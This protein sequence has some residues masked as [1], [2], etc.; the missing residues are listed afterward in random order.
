MEDLEAA[1]AG[2]EGG[3]FGGVVCGA[4][5][6]LLE[7]LCARGVSKRCKRSGGTISFTLDEAAAHAEALS[8]GRLLS[9]RIWRLSKRA[10]TGSLTMDEALQ[11]IGRRSMLQMIEE[12]LGVGILG[13]GA[14]G[15]HAGIKYVPIH[16]AMSFRGAGP[17]APR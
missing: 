10:E 11:A 4:R 6:R 5:A 3:R 17:N 9:G 8:P 1:E 13:G 12:H 16:P 7:V 2:R 14:T 15:K